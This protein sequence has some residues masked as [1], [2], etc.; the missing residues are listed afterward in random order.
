MDEP[1]ARDADLFSRVSPGPLRLYQRIA[2]SIRAL[3]LVCL[4]ANAAVAQTSTSR[5]VNAAHNFLSTLDPHGR[6]SALFAF[7]DEQQRR[8]WSNFP[9]AVVP[10]SGLSVGELN[11]A[12][13]S[14]A[15]GLISSAL[16]RR[17]FEK[18]R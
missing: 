14:A 6:E 11:T 5:I 8:R 3:A 15:L 10:R 17:G 7:D 16:S 2:C 4:S 9:T 1:I 12:Q 18:V 13:R